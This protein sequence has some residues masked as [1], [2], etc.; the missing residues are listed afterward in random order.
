MSVEKENLDQYLLLALDYLKQNWF[1]P[2]KGFVACVLVDGQ[3]IVTT[4]NI[5][6]SSA[7]FKHAELRAIDQ[8]EK[9]H[10]P[11]SSNAIAVITLSPCIVYSQK[12]KGPP[13][14]ALLL[15]KGVKRIHFG[16]LHRKQGTLKTYSSLGF[17]ASLT[18]NRR[19]KNICRALLSLYRKNKKQIT[20]ESTSWL[21]IK[22]KVGLSLFE[23]T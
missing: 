12:R 22:E 20:S 4:T 1:S 17:Y 10:G 3:N 14:A 2:N 16:F 8:F 23:Q 21:H 19:I 9:Q 18:D 6:L 5:F 11:L 13:C 15:K 7:K